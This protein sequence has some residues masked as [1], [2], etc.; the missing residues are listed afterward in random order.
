MP[1]DKFGD[2][3]VP[4]GNLETARAILA[5]CYF[6]HCL[7]LMTRYA[8]LLAKPD[9]ARRF[10]GLA[11]LLKDGMNDTLYHRDKG[12]YDNGS[13]TSCLLP[14]A[15]DMVPSH[16]RSRAFDCLTKDIT[17][18]CNSHVGMGLVGGQWLNR[19][20]TDGGRPDLA[21]RLATN[22]TYPC[23]GYM[24][25]KGATT[26]WELWDGDTAGP[27]MN[28]GNHV[29]LVGDLVTWFHEC[30]AGIMPDPAQPGFKQIIMKPRPVGD[31]KFVE[32]THRSPYGLIVSHWN[33]VGDT[34]DWQISVPPNTTATVH[35]PAKV[36]TGVTE[37]G[38]PADRADGVRFLKMEHGAAVYEV[39]AGTYR[40]RSNN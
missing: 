26:I 12:L 11:A 16:E 8:T 9:D 13:Q 35:V 31:L 23:L 25:E 18:R 20:L 32:A 22:T 27:E 37:S 33:R 24:V 30:L 4:P 5:T 7:K 36:A 34:F 14:L 28:S 40:F 29:M 17:E 38:H 2:W 10:A 21:Y 1:Q 19:V 39:G 3:C 15:F 6:H